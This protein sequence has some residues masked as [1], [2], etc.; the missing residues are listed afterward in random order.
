MSGIFICLIEF[1]LFIFILDVSQDLLE[2]DNSKKCDFYFYGYA[3]NFLLC[4][5]SHWL[6]MKKIL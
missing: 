3:A 5:C 2:K 1:D 6:C 4:V